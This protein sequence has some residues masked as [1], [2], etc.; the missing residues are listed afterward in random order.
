MK[1]GSADVT[2]KAVYESNIVETIEPTL[3]INNST[4]SLVA[5]EAK[6]Y[7]WYFNNKLISSETK[8]TLTINQN[9][10]YTV[11]MVL[12][13]GSTKKLSVS[14]A[15][16]KDGVIRKIYLIGDSTVC[17]YKDNQYPMTGWGQVLKY[18]F[19]SDIQINNHAI[20]GRSS[21]SFIEQGRW[22]TVLEALQPGDFVFIQF[23]HNDRD[24][25]PERYTS[26]ADYKKNMQMFVNDARGKGLFLYLFL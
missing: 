20:G 12:N 15:I 22:K 8:S 26:V 13:D 2:Y 10:T 9:G 5:S 19:N 25:K 3:T 7:K 11:E 21:R 24:T 23:G 16:G 6:S 14:V 4:K 1:V 18:F 17:N